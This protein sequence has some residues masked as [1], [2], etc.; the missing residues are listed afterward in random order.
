[1]RVLMA[2]GGMVG[3]M[4]VGSAPGAAAAGPRLSLELAPITREIVIDGVLSAGE[5]GSAARIERFFE[6]WPGDNTEPVVG[7]VGM[8]AYDRTALYVAFEC[9]D[10]EPAA[11]RAFIGDRDTVYGDQDFVSVDV[12]PD[13]NE[14]SSFLF[15]VN[16]G[17]VQGDG[18][19][20][21]DTGLDDFSPDFEFS[22]RAAVGPGGWTV[23]MRIPFSSIRASEQT[24]HPWRLMLFRN[25]PR[26]FRYQMT[27]SPLVRGTGVWLRASQLLSGIRD[28]EPSGLVATPHA[29]FSSGHGQGSA[30][31]LSGGVDAKWRPRGDL[32]IDL[33]ARPDFSQVESDSP[34]IAVNNRFALFFPEKRDFFLESIQLFDTPF[35]V[36]HTRTITAPDWGLRATGQRGATSYSVLAAEDAGGGSVVLPGSQASELAAQDFRSLVLVSRLTHAT[37][38]SS[39]GFTLT[40][41]DASGGG[42]NLVLG[43]DLVWRPNEHD[44]LR[45]QVLWSASETPDRPDLHPRWTGERLE[46]H[47]ASLSWSRE[48]E[49]YDLMMVVEDVDDELRADV[50]FIPR[51]GY[52]RTG[53][54]VGLRRYR[55][56]SI[57]YLRLSVA[58]DSYEDRGGRTL[59]RSWAPTV[60]LVGRWNATLTVA[61]RSVEERVGDDRVATQ[62]G[63]LSFSIQPSRRLPSLDL[64]AEIGEGVDLASGR[65]GD[66]LFLRGSAVIRPTRRLEMVLEGSLERLDLDD[67]DAS[68]RLFDGEVARLRLRYGFSA[69]SFLRI[70]AQRAENRRTGLVAGSIPERSGER[71]VS[72]VFLHRWSSQ[73]ALWIGWG[74]V[75]TLDEL[76]RYRSS[77]DAVFAKLA[78]GWTLGPGR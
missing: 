3:L 45:G 52:R 11:I 13:G 33:T 49:R 32:A 17:S 48:D 25:Y 12:D 22:S 72:I 31:G 55:D 1:M 10:P 9:E 60:S 53:G 77:G 76:G 28:I 68:G 24:A 14:K 39:V 73:T 78:Y 46:G 56:A 23:E 50:G 54:E 62:R 38:A 35:Q 19:Y 69:T 21:E 20:S 30:D 5:W 59:L 15:R 64:A 29:T 36:V 44:S 34:Q 7:T 6:I 70:I 58:A 43:P 2:A 65:R 42:S 61:A 37:G 67:E 27:S 4:V 71:S 47:A 18:T 74:D 75:E 63:E 26:Q 16:P 51:V 57:S 40:G 66:R 8:V 41:R